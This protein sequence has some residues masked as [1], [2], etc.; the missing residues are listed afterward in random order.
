M[1]HPTTLED[2]RREVRIFLAEQLALG[3]FRP[4]CDSW[5]SGFSAEFS[6]SLA[7]R[8]WLGMTWPSRYGGHERSEVERFAVTEE[9]L[10]AGAPV[11][12]HWFADRQV[13]PALL[14]HGTEDQRQSLLPAMARGEC[15]V[16]IGLSEPDSG[17]DLASVRTTAAPVA[18]G[19]NVN[20]TKVWTSHAQHCQYMLTLLRTAPHDNLDR[21]TGLSQVLIDLTSPGVSVRPIPLLDGHPHFNE[22]SLTDVFVP[23]EHLLGKEGAG[24]QQVISE[25]AYERSGPERILSTFPLLA[26]VFQR[27]HHADEFIGPLLAEL[28]TLRHMSVGIARQIERGSAPPVEAALVKDLGTQFEN[29]VIEVSRLI[30]AVEPDVRSPDTLVRLLA[31]AVLHA[32]A[33]TLRGGTSEVLRGIVAKSVVR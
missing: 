6:R 3:A 30:A 8:G 26:E 4:S 20:G 28:M 33:F 2:P 25:L 1:T 7:E 27:E 10:A 24:W 16:A 5:L 22:V 29:R 19:W 17:S 31:E 32:P 21:H 12:A 14:K 11:A 9:L 23:H 13:G 18:G 15:F